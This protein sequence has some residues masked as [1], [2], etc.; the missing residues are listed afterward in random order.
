MFKLGFTLSALL[1]LSACSSGGS[2][3]GG[4]NDDAGVANLPAIDTGASGLVADG[5]LSDTELQSVDG[6]VTEEQA[7]ALA[8]GT[9]EYTVPSSQCVISYSFGDVGDFS[10]TSLDK[11]GSGEYEF[12][13]EDGGTQIVFFYERD[14]LQTDCYGDIENTLEP[15][16][17]YSNYI[18]FPDQNTMAL[19]NNSSGTSFRRDFIR[20]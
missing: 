13:D 9:W 14:N 19:S 20:Q 15:G 4:A 8:L 1:I 10:E 3:S 5:A 16:V 7:A 6:V 11:A 17:S 2:D 12:R 18:R